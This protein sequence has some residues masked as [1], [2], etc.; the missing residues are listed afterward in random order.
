MLFL[1][2]SLENVS[3]GGWDGW[4][5]LEMVEKKENV[6]FLVHSGCDPHFL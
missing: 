6:I 1:Y 2:Q 3:M 4:G 5:G